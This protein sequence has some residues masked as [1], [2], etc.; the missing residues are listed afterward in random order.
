MK[1]CS[2][3][4]ALLVAAVSSC[5]AQPAASLADAGAQRAPGPTLVVLVT[6]DQLR[7]DYLDRFAPQYRGGLARLVRGGARF[8]NAHHDHAMTETAPG[9]ATLL[10][11][12]FPRSTGIESNSAGVGDSTMPLI[13]AESALGASP[14]RFR[15]T[16]LADWLRSRDRRSRALSVSGKDRAAILPIGRSKQ[17]VYWYGPGGRFTTSRYYG[18]TLPEW[19]RRFNARDEARRLA[20]RAWELML[21]DSAYRE[22]DSVSVEGAGRDYVFPHRVPADSAA[23]A[24]YVRTTP[25]YDEMAFNLAL[26]GLGVLG[27]GAGP[28]TD[29]LAVSLSATDHIGHTYGPDSREIHDQMLRLDRALGV[30]LDSLFRLRD[31]SRVVLALSADHGVSRIPELAADGA[32]S[33]PMRVE[34]DSVVHHMQEALRAAGADPRALIRGPMLVTVNRATLERGSVSVDSALAV[35]AGVARRTPGV[36]RVDRFRD[37]RGADTVRDAIARRWLHHF[38]ADAAPDL[39]VTLE[40]LSVWGWGVATHGSPHDA[41]SHVPLIFYGPPFRPGRYDEFVRTVDLAPTL[42]AAAGVRPT[43]KLDGV[44]LRQ[45]L[46]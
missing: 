23:A 29:L 15:G 31:S 5:R 17:Q 1:L 12:R 3:G 30:F 25:W 6:V 35:L 20:G 41:D 39:V 8:T 18:D 13:G 19:V 36:L 2:L 26:E 22:R 21:A 28:Q 46:K 37:L 27:L 32:S 34:A 9:H 16:T 45:A 24:E 43:E 38:P 33:P 10:S 14:R 44:V 42:A 7:A 11:G 40:P 4:A